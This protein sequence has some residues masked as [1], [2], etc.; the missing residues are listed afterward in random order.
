MNDLS[1][2]HEIRGQRILIAPLNWGLGHAARCIPIIKMLS[3]HNDILLGSD[4]D[5]LEL[6]VQ[7]FP[8]MSYVKLPPYNIHYKDKHFL[9][10]IMKQSP[11]MIG[12]IGQEMALTSDIVDRFKLDMIISDHRLGCRDKRIKSIIIAHQLQIQAGTKIASTLGSKTNKYFINAFDQCWIPDY[13][14]ESMRLSGK[15]ADHDGIKSYKYIGPLSRMLRSK[16]QPVN[17]IAVVLSGPE[18]QRSLI[19]KKLYTLLKTSSWKITWVRGVANKKEDN[20]PFMETDEVYNLA[21]VSSLNQI[22]NQS[23][24]VIARSGYTT[25]MDMAMLNKECVLIP[26]PGQTE[27]E[28]LK[29]NLKGRKN[30]HFLEE[31]QLN[32]LNDLIGSVI[33]Y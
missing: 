22:I 28:Y 29:D 19:E 32:H 4:G 7:E 15:L 12:A 26:T 18:P 20:S 27:Q 11:K 9:W 16:K 14:A 1:F 13:E 24:L 25:I 3:Q 33:T 23:K 21:T 8:Q 30:F 5:A 17:D 2:L 6:L 31:Q 10:G